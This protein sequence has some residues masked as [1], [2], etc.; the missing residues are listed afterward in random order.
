ML[1]YLTDFLKTFAWLSHELIVVK[2]KVFEV[3]LNAP[4]LIR[5]NAGL[6]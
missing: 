3:I 5:D 6:T 4:K 1:F 2:L